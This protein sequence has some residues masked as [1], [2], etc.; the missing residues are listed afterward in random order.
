MVTTGADGRLMELWVILRVAARLRS[1][2][3]RRARAAGET[4]RDLPRSC[5]LWEAE[6]IW[7]GENRARIG[8]PTSF[9]T[10]RQP[11]SR[12]RATNPVKIPSSLM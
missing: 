1:S 7:L 4:V 12:M 6:G 9:K 5:V 11:L 8:L 10:R 3:A 2:D